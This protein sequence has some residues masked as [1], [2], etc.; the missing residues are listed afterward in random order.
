MGLLIIWILAILAV[1]TALA[2]LGKIARDVRRIADA[3]EH[4]QG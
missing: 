4:K 2:L 1:N 3:V